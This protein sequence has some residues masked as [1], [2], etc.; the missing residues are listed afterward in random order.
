MSEVEIKDKILLTI[1]EA[2][3]YSNIGIN[4]LYAISKKPNCTFSVYSG[5][6]ILIKR[7]SFEKYIENCVEI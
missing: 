6:K 4:K 2:S 5:N 7:K 3:L 1:R